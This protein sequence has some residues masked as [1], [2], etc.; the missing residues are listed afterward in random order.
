MIQSVE[1]FNSFS[2]LGLLFFTTTNRRV[3]VCPGVFF[4]T[5]S[6]MS[7]MTRTMFLSILRFRMGVAYLYLDSFEKPECHLAS[8]IS[9]ILREVF[10]WRFED[11]LLGGL[12]VW[13]PEQL[14]R[15]SLTSCICYY[16]T[17]RFIHLE[18]STVYFLRLQYLFVVTQMQ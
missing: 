5:E 14:G 10:E 3:I 13:E 12:S 1:T 7:V 18:H 2:K 4:T 11:F 17:N 15:E 9:F 16:L 8:L 6:F